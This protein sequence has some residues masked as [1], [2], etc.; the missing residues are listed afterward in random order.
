[1]I[2]KGLAKLA[3]IVAV[4]GAL[5]VGF[6]PPAQ[7]SIPMTATGTFGFNLIS[8]TLVRTVGTTSVYSEVA[9]VP[10]S[11]G[12]SGTATDRETDIVNNK[13]GSWA[14]VGTEVCT[15]CT[16]GGRAGGYTAI[17]TDAGSNYFTT[18]LPYQGY[19]IITGGTSG[20]AGMHGG[21]MFGGNASNPAFYSYNY[22]FAT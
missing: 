22:S 13:N 16:L 20:L 2:T 7:A 8:L 17:Y 12:L 10:Y 18:A 11:G 4:L 19:L 6:G 5:V 15:S 14:G 9:D 3:S 21:G 1:V